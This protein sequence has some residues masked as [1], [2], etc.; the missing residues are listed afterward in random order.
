MLDRHCIVLE[1]PAWSGP[2]FGTRAG[3]AAAES[4]QLL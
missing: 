1:R 4:Y 3:Q 2:R